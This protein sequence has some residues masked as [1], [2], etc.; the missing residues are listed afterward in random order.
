[1]C[2]NLCQMLSAGIYMRVCMSTQACFSPTARGVCPFVH[3]RLMG[4]RRVG[5][6]KTVQQAVWRVRTHITVWNAKKASVRSTCRMANVLLGVKGEKCSFKT[7]RMLRSHTR[8][9]AHTGCIPNCICYCN[10][11]NVCFLFKYILFIFLFYFAFFSFL[12]FCCCF[13]VF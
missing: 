4:T 11:L 13:F 6:V 7:H 2:S 8:S 9:H 10:L 1:M 3:V 12:T 5:A